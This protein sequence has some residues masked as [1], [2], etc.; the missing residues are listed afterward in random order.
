MTTNTPSSGAQSPSSALQASIAK[1]MAR[2]DA[3]FGE[4]KEASADMCASVSTPREK[5]VTSQSNTA[6]GKCFARERFE[7][8]V[9]G[10]ACLSCSFSNGLVMSWWYLCS[11]AKA[12]LRV[13]VSFLRKRLFASSTMLVDSRPVNN[14][15]TPT[16]TSMGTCSK[17]HSASKTSTSRIQQS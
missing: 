4:E 7:A 3:A 9:S 12:C 15:R 1:D 11:L 5:S 6:R 8:S 16:S 2:H 10:G 13:L 14:E 17:D